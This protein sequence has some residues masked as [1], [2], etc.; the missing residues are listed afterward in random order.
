MLLASFASG[1]TDTP[2]QQVRFALPGSMDEELRIAIAVNQAELQE[3][4][5]EAFYLNAEARSYGSARARESRRHSPGYS[6]P[7]HHK[8]GRTLKHDN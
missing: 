8:A 3:R 7:P 2:E 6:S 4:K 5:N 1:L